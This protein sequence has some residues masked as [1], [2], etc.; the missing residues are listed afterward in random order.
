[1]LA[2]QYQLEHS[3][4]LTASELLSLQH[5]QLAVLL[6]HA[7]STVPFYRDR[8]KDFDAD[9]EKVLEPALWKTIPILERRD[10]QDAANTLLSERIPKDHQPLNKIQTSGSTGTPITAY[11]TPVTR[12]FWRAFTLRDHLWHDRDLSLEFVAIRPEGRLE[13]GQSLSARGW[14]A[15][16]DCAFQTG[17]SALLTVRTD[18]QD[19]VDWLVTRNPHYLL[20]LPTNIIEL[21]KHF[22]DSGKR[23]PELREIRTYGE[24][25][26]PEVREICREVFNVAV[27]DMYSCQEV[28]YI[29][30]QCPQ[31]SHYHI[32]SE[33]LLVEIL[34]EQGNECSP[35][36]TGRVVITTLHNFAMPLIRYA[37]GDYARVGEACDCG[38]GLPVISEV[39]GRER[40]MVRLPDGRTHYPSFPAEMWMNTGPIR[41]LQL[42]QTG[43]N[44]IR[45][46]LCCD[47][48]LK[49]PEHKAF[50]AMLQ[51]RLDY[52][53]TI[54]IDYLEQIERGK[55]GKFEDFVSELD[56]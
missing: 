23:L 26:R 55:N 39:L 42:V 29:A 9:P 3:E 38:R 45:A 4:H 34:D 35:G 20:S 48:P 21:A 31:H 52:P 41:Q 56:N 12:L 25:A 2:M 33:S 30:L 16:T 15:A 24:V 37:L 50:V 46:R 28:G 1:M 53:F 44:R 11:G 54:E 10:I 40:N 47:R 7:R 14:G 51:K 13:P 49:D 43:I 22:R 17:D 8:L 6:Q 36:E 19:Q 27:T 32:Q 18:I 5:Q